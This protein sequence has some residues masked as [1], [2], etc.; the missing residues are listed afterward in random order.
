MKSARRFLV[1]VLCFCASATLPA[2]AEAL[3]SPE[4]QAFLHDQAARVV[5]LARVAPGE[6]SGSATNTT[7]YVM[8]LPDSHQVYTAFWVR[9]SNMAL[10]ADFVSAGDVRDWIKLMCATISNKD[11]QVRPDVLVPAYSVPDHINFDGKPTFFPGNYEEGDKQGG[12]DL[13]AV[14]LLDDAFFFLFTVNEYASMTKSADLF[15]SQ[16]ATPTGPMILSDLCL[17]VFDAIPVDPATGIPMTGDVHQSNAWGKDFGFCD[18][19]QK[20]GKLLF[21]AV[22]KYD[23]ARRLAPLYREI[24]NQA[25]ADHLTQVADQIKKNLTTVFYH[26]SE[27]PREGW[28]YSATGECH[29]PDVWGSAYAVA[30]GAVD[31]ETARKVERSLLR[32]YQD[33]SLVNAG[34]VSEV[35]QHDPANPKGWQNT[36]LP[37]GIYQNGG[38]WP[39]GTGWYIVALNAID[40][41]AARAMA[42]DY[43]EFMHANRLEDGTSQ[44]WEWF[45]PGIN[46]YEH[47]QYVASAAFAYGILNRAGLLGGSKSEPK[48]N[49][50]THD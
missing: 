23:A 45:N 13:G 29:Q 25:A 26:D 39:T 15:K 44:A 18:T 40:P 28:L 3:L 6:K 9:D 19:I 32:G 16:V 36:V 37:F 14:P 46:H 11:W 33:R 35:L 12:G 48:S 47:P 30:V 38:Y 31:G 17:K 42:K 21:T 27:H 50:A 34:C 10:G 5:R 24:G 7:P 20:S 22:L 2:K 1:P 8:H 41:K 49:S 43:V 4:D